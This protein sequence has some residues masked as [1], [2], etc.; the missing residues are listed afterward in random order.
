MA[1][2]RVWADLSEET[3]RAYTCEAQ[4][5][6]VDVEAL[7]EQTVNTLLRELEE[8]IRDGTD[9]PITPT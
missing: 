1:K 2:V 3:F 6:G 8:Q 7:V 5:R 4:R 9:H